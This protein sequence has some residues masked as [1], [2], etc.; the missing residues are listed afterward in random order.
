MNDKPLELKYLTNDL[1]VSPQ[2][3]PED[4]KKVA[5]AGFK[6][7][8]INLPDFE[9][10]DTQPTAASIISVAESFGLTTAYLPVSTQTITPKDCDAFVNLTDCLPKPI[11][12]FCR[13]GNR[14]T[15]LFN[16]QAPS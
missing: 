6:S 12:A 8:I 15:I 14:C 9:L 11:L 4:M 3:L 16:R 1:A 2:L 7:L 5:A 10:G 13:S